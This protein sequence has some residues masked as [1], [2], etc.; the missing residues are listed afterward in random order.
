MQAYLQFIKLKDDCGKQLEFV[1][2]DDAGEMYGL[3]QR[4]EQVMY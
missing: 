2:A 3:V 1:L 4:R